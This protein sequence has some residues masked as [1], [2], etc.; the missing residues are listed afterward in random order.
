M[1]SRPRSVPREQPLVHADPRPGADDRGHAAGADPRRV[2][3]GAGARPGSAAAAALLPVDRVGRAVRDHR[4]RHPVLPGPPRPDRA[5]RRA[6]PATSRASTAPTSCATCATRWA[7]SSTTPTGSTT[8]EEWVEHFGSITQPY[9][10]EYRPE[11]FSRRFVRHLPGWYAQKHPDEDWA[12]TFA[13]WMTPGLRLARRVRRLARRRWPSSTTATA[14]MAE[15]ARPRA[16]GDRR[17]AGRG[18]RRARATRSSSTTATSAGDGAEPARRASTARCG[19]SSRT[20]AQ[21]EDG[22]GRRRRAGRPRS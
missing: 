21:P 11:P 16:A 10:E 1:A 8:S 14:L 18:R 17:R 13:V 15:L 5:A 2:R 19:R 20:S 12:E 4:D 9:L 7:T 6:R 22:A 3:G